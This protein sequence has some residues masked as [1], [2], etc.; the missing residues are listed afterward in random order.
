M[1]Q[2]RV[3]SDPPLKMQNIL[4]TLSNEELFIFY[5]QSIHPYWQIKSFQ[6]PLTH[7]TFPATSQELLTELN[8]RESKDEDDFS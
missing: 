6:H 7:E 1:I 3:L 4:T 5:K 8:R 2:V